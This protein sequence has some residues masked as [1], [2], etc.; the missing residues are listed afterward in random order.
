MQ[1]EGVSLAPYTVNLSLFDGILTRS[2]GTENDS[3]VSN[4]Q[5]LLLSCFFFCFRRFKFL[6]LR[7]QMSKRH[8]EHSSMLLRSAKLPLP[9]DGGTFPLLFWMNQHSRTQSYRDYSVAHSF[10]LGYL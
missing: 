3:I 6:F 2:S 1:F 7:A 5:M 10:S 8:W 4:V 9:R